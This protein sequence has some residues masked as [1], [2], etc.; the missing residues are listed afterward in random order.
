MEAL[1]RALTASWAEHAPLDVRRLL[2][3]GSVL[4]VLFAAYRLGRHTLMAL[5]ILVTVVAVMG[6]MKWRWKR[7]TIPYRARRL[8]SSRCEHGAEPRPERDS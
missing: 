4:L 2:L 5:A 1:V 7:V 6:A 3:A 8:W